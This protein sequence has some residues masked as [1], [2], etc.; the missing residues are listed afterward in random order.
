MGN[1]L[2]ETEPTNSMEG[3]TIITDVHVKCNEPSKLWI[4]KKRLDAVINNAVD[5]MDDDDLSEQQLP[6]AINTQENTPK[7]IKRAEG[8]KS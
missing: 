7:L 1:T 3:T 4:P 2:E 6:I 5:I 8:F